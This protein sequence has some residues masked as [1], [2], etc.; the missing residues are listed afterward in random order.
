MKEKVLPTHNIEDLFALYTSKNFQ[1]IS[2]L[3]DEK[4]K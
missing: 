1:H 2:K 3:V 4:R